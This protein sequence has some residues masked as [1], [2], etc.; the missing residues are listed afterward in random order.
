MEIFVTQPRLSENKNMVIFSS[1]KNGK[2]NDI[3][4]GNHANH[5]KSHVYYITRIF[6]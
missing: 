5:F 3:V 4:F 1:T 2:L 6:K